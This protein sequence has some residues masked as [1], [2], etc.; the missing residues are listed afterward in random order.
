[1]RVRTIAGTVL[2]FLALAACGGDSATE[3][4][5]AAPALQGAPYYPPGMVDNPHAAV[6]DT[7]RLNNG[8]F[9]SGHRS[10]P[11]DSS[12]VIIY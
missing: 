8:Y 7:S 4:Q 6:R 10:P 9:G 12:R 11:D 5:V 1:M 3:P 2:A